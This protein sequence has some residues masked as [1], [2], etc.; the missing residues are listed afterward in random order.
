LTLPRSRIA[1]MQCQ[2]SPVRSRRCPA[3]VVP[4]GGEPG[5]LFCADVMA[6]DGRAVR[7][8]PLTAGCQRLSACAAGDDR[9]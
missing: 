8:C 1:V 7:R 6:L 3:P 5:R 9:G 2:R 4:F